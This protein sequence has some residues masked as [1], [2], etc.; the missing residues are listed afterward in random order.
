MLRRVS[1]SPDN[2]SIQIQIPALDT[3]I[4]NTPNNA[5]NE[6]LQHHDSS[7]VQ[8]RSSTRTSMDLT[9]KGTLSFHN[10]SYMIGGRQKIGRCKTCYPPFIKPKPKKQIIDN[11]SGIFTT[12]MNA[13]MG[14]NSLFPLELG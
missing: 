3:S 4:S 11:V 5:S 14:K 12:G 9:S 8:S 2:V 13:I 7:E 6:N 1:L 10:I